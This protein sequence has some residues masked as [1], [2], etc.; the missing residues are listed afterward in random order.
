MADEDDREDDMTR[1]E[2]VDMIKNLLTQ[3]QNYE[4]LDFVV[5]KIDFAVTA[6]RRNEERVLRGGIRDK[7]ETRN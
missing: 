3:M 1:E 7:K 6:C 4:L 2:K 5:V